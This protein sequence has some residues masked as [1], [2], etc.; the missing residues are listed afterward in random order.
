MSRLHAF[1]PHPVVRQIRHALPPVL[2]AACAERVPE[3]ETSRCNAG[4]DRE[5][6]GESW[7]G[8]SVGVRAPGIGET[9]LS[10]HEVAHA[11]REGLV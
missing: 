3:Q 6:S 8:C 4:C 7:P 11:V 2:H 1:H 9:P 10:F 5:I